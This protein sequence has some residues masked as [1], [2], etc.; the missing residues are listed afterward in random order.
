[1]IPA[2]HEMM[3]EARYDSGAEEWYCPM[4]GQRILITW[5]DNF[6][7]TILEVGDSF[8]LHSGSRGLSI[9]ASAE[10][11]PPVEPIPDDDPRLAAFAEWADDVNTERLW[12]SNDH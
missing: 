2:R 12:E 4:C 7:K 5:G 3:L 1:M 9:R 6:Q 10:Q 11:T 8:A